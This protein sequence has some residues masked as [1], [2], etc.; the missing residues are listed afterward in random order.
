MDRAE[1]QDNVEWFTANYPYELI[2]DMIN[3][4][5]GDLGNDGFFIARLRRV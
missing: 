1:N 5:P 2:T 4:A 3:I